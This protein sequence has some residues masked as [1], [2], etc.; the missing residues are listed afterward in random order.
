MHEGRPNSVYDQQIDP[1]KLGHDED[2]RKWKQK[3]LVPCG[4][5]LG[6]KRNLTVMS[7]EGNMTD[8]GAQ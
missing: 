3:K 4:Y 8:Q 7:P 1:V 5:E 6:F 2:L